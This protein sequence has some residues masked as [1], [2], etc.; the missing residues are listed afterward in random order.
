MNGVDGM[1]WVR[2]NDEA[3]VLGLEIVCA[4]FFLFLSFFLVYQNRARYVKKRT[5]LSVALLELLHFP[6]LQI[7]SRDTRSDSH[8]R[9]LLSLPNATVGV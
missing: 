5:V 6:P 2:R 9:H 7:I 3:L 4:S 8:L 1:S